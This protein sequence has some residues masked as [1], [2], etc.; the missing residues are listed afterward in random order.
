M[1]T[2]KARNQLDNNNNTK[3]RKGYRKWIWVEWNA[4]LFPQMKITICQCVSPWWNRT[5]MVTGTTINVE[6][7]I[8]LQEEFAVTNCGGNQVNYRATQ[9]E[10]YAEHNTI[11]IFW[12]TV[13]CG[14]TTNDDKLRV[15]RISYYNIFGIMKR[16]IN[17]PQN[18]HVFQ[19]SRFIAQQ[20]NKNVGGWRNEC[21]KSCVASN[22][23]NQSNVAT[24]QRFVLRC[25]F[26]TCR[27]QRSCLPRTSTTTA[28]NLQS[29]RN[30]NY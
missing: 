5:R 11:I 12:Q 8:P 19:L 7:F 20:I 14:W 18:D 21:K 24:W 27:L 17:H 6:L 25:S 1:V 13:K 2:I 30:G 22:R 29:D 28:I 23:S 10:R 15:G 9:N 26:S 4:I 16:A 3:G